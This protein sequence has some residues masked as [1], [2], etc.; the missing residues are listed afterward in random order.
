MKEQLSKSGKRIKWGAI[1]LILSNVSLKYF[2]EIIFKIFDLKITRFSDAETCAEIIKY[3]VYI[4]E[5]SLYLGLI[6][7]LTAGSALINIGGNSEKKNEKKE[8]YDKKTINKKLRELNETALNY[9]SNDLDKSI[10]L[11]KS[12]LEI[13][14][15]SPNTNY[16]I[17][18]CYSLKKNKEK[19]YYHLSC[20]INNGYK[21]LNLI[22]EDKDL[23]WL[24][25]QD[26]FK[27]FIENNY[28]LDFID[29]INNSL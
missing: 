28:T 8:V 5:V 22:T 20:A 9:K 1:L 3:N 12:A 24:R 18:C 13:K 11:L 15:N 4:S 2:S 7:L 23:N 27:T 29:E 16:H 21:K 19:A 17:A 10:E 26:E 14:F 25:E 6:L